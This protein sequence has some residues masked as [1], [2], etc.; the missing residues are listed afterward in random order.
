MVPHSIPYKTAVSHMAVS[1]AQATSRLRAV[2]D[3][4]PDADE[5][6]K[7]A[8]SPRSNLTVCPECE[9]PVSGLHQCAPRVAEAL[10]RMEVELAYMERDLQ[11]LAAYDEG[12]AE[13]QQWAQGVQA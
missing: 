8:R 13:Y 9:R 2:G 4:D 1:G 6:L 11:P 5:L 12:L 7:R 10:F 3:S